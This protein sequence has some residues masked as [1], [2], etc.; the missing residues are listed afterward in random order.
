MGTRTMKSIRTLATL[1]LIGL[2]WSSFACDRSPA[3]RPS[4]DRVGQSQTAAS[5][6]AA[7]RKPK[8]DPPTR[9][10]PDPIA[11]NATGGGASGAAGALP[12]LE[13]PGR[14]VAIG[15]VHGDFEVTRQVLRLARA[16]DAKDRWVGG[17]LVVVQT[18]DQLD[19][20][21]H[22]LEILRL[23]ERLGTDAKKAGG[24]FVALN[25]NHETMTVAG[26]FRYVTPGGFEQ[27][28]SFDQ[29]QAVPQPIVAH[30][31]ERARGRYLAFH[32][33]A[34]LALLLSQR[35]LVALVDDNLFAHGGVL[36]KHVG[37]GL[38][39]INREVQA[40]MRGESDT[41]RVVFEDDAPVWSRHYSVPQPTGETCAELARVLAQ[42]G[43]ARLV[44]GHTV[45]TKGI[46]SACDDR[47]WRI[48]VG[49][50]AYYNG[51]SVQALEIVGDQVKVLSA[52]KAPSQ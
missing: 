15:D 44:V 25:G 34:E 5:S 37:Y 50:A 47:V 31:G 19:R 20:G 4:S 11:V 3:P 48:D 32:P 29:E 18:G 26:D 24:A 16:I 13:A 39:R 14:I 33:G 27:F 45:H 21:D 49:L 23:F 41:A 35:P 28:K 2:G 12:R 46:S 8:P 40:W 30:F 52:A 10:D 42:V 36:E 9:S 22:E 43:A 1:G 51:N 7:E 6:Q 38:E 17:E